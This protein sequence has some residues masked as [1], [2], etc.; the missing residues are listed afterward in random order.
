MD[1][2][3][4]FSAEPC[5]ACLRPLGDERRLSAFDLDCRHRHARH[6]GC[7]ARGEV[8]I[9]CPT[10][11]PARGDAVGGVPHLSAADAPRAAAAVLVLGGAGAGKTAAV[12]EL[13]RLRLFPG[14][15][16]VALTRGA[17]DEY[18]GAVPRAM[19][20]DGVTATE[21]AEAVLG[22][23]RRWARHDAATAITVVVDGAGR[24]AAGAVRAPRAAARRRRRRRR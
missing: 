9:L 12:R 22:A 19:I 14:Y 4:R 16:R 2:A 7:Y 3:A 5:G 24:G 23:V 6:T 11:L 17:A 10:L 13:L 21:R 20:H 1:D 15:Y 8:C 18:V